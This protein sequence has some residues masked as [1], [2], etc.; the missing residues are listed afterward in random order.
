VRRAT[1]PAL[2]FLLCVS[3][4]HYL[5]EGSARQTAAYNALGEPADLS[6]LP[7]SV[8]G[9]P[10]DDPS[11]AGLDGFELSVTAGGRLE[12]FTVT[13]GGDTA[14]GGG[15]GLGGAGLALDYAADGWGFAGAVVRRSDFAYRLEEGDRRLALSGEV[16]GLNGAVSYGERL[17]F[18]LGVEGL[19]GGW[20]Y[21]E[22]DG[23][24]EEA[25]LVGWR[26][27]LGLR[28][29]ES[30]WGFGL[31][32][33][34]PAELGRGPGLPWEAD[35]WL[36]LPLVDRAGLRS[37][38]EVAAGGYLFGPEAAL[39]G[40]QGQ[41]YS[42]RLGDGL[43]GRVGLSW[44]IEEDLSFAVGAFLSAYP[45]K[46]NDSERLLWQVYSLGAG[47]G[48]N[49]RWG[50]EASFSQVGTEGED[51][52]ACGALYLRLGLDFGL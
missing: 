11:A 32:A 34:G 15:A 6:A 42:A 52:Y 19:Y 18:G 9:D 25:E 10:S 17:R 20:R 44:D 27:R 38:L 13:S 23:G 40:E 26:A 3:C 16:W 5:V 12:R 14:Y 36:A 21:E 24:V 39:V 28:Y 49:P 35:L 8:T 2:A 22:L 29:G 47:F 48:K 30:G 46:D 41:D 37:V 1:I 45:V 31:R 33:S 43:R 50:V 4:S 7:D 51:G